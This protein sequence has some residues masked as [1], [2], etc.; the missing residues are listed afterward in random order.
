MSSKSLSKSDHE[1]DIVFYGCVNLF[2]KGVVCGVIDVWRCRSCDQ[3]FCEEKRYV[4][5]DLAPEVG[6]P[7]VSPGTKWA[8]LACHKDKELAWSLV[9]AKPN[10]DITHKCVEES[11]QVV[12]VLGNL[13]VKGTDQEVKHLLFLIESN[14]N[15]E[16][17]IGPS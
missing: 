6:M 11:E 1:H 7:P 2:N 3:K 10:D 13:D 17:E 15:K 14:V 8:V 5:T 16:I 9:Q 4:F 12:R